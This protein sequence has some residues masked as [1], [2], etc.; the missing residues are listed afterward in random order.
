[1]SD[2]LPHVTRTMIDDMRAQTGMCAIDVAR[3]FDLH[4]RRIAIERARTNSLTT[5]E[6]KLDLILAILDAEAYREISTRRF[7][8][9]PDSAFAED[10]PAPSEDDDEPN[11]ESDDNT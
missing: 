11:D 10:F 1:M 5:T 2:L 3:S 9:I 8:D 7:P 4:A 6:D